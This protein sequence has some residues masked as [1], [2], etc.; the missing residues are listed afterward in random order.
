M[1][2]ALTAPHAQRADVITF[3]RILC[4]ID[5]SETSTKALVYA[6]AFATW[7][8]AH[9]EVL[10]VA[11]AFDDAFIP[12]TTSV[13]APSPTLYPR[14]REELLIE[15]RR[16]VGAAGATVASSQLLVQESPIHEMIVNRARAQAIDLLVIGTHGRSGFN[17]LFLGSVTEKVMRPVSCPVLTVPPAAPASQTTPVALRRIVCAIDDSPPSRKALEYALDL[18]RQ[19]DGRA[20]VLHVLEYMN[21]NEPPEPSPSDL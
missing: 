4:P 10:H 2:V 14:S 11:P 6:T 8:D 13:G 12:T 16:T 18:A 9:L 20:I 19:A 5:F 1:S 3:S 21:P 7:Y 15:M 17:R